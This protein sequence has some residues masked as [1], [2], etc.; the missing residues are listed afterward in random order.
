V[1]YVVAFERLGFPLATPLVLGI[2]LASYGERR[3]AVLTGVSLGITAA[4]YLVFARWLGAPLPL[5][6]LGS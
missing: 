1:A 4:T 2:L 6:I 3:W 5:G